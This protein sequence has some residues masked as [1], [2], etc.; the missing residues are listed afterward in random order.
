MRG[1]ERKREKV[2]SWQGDECTGDKMTAEIFSS[3]VR[4]VFF[5][6]HFGITL[7]FDSKTTSVSA[8]QSLVLFQ[9]LQDAYIRKVLFKM[10]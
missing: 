6:S 9:K 10:E 1:E 8:I 2:S 4:L 3:F 5:S 7:C